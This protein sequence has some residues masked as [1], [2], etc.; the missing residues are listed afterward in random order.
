M[1]AAEYARHRFAKGLDGPRQLPRQTISAAIAS[2]AIQ[3]LPD[4]SVDAEW[5]DE[6]WA[7]ENKA[8]KSTGPL[9]DINR[10]L[11]ELELKRKT[12]DMKAAEGKMLDRE[13]AL[14]TYEAI[15]RRIGESIDRWPERAAAALVPVLAKLGCR[16]KP[17]TITAALDTVAHE[18]R[19]L[20]AQDITAAIAQVK[21]KRR[22]T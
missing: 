5:A 6:N 9:A 10:Q 14:S 15:G 20:I 12:A 11:A 18:T 7:P 19:A 22:R 16:V 1:T 8:P 2:G 21:P 13:A 4:G 3:T 17:R